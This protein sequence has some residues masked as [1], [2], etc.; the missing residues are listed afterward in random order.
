MKVPLRYFVGGVLVLAASLI[1]WLGQPAYLGYLRSNY[2][3]IVPL[4][5]LL[6][7]LGAWLCFKE[8]M[9]ARGRD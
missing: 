9:A 6:G 7:C 4:A 2:Q 8:L 5:M 1:M 3:W